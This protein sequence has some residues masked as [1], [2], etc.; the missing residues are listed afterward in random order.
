MTTR[1]ELIQS[2]RTAFAKG[3]EW[4]W[5]MA[6]DDYDIHHVVINALPEAAEHYPVP[7]VPREVYIDGRKYRVT[8]N[9]GFEY[10][11][12]N[13]GYWSP[14]SLTAERVAGLADLL[15]NPLT[16]APDTKGQ[17]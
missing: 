7:K 4:G 11:N 14:S 15:K 6:Q 8:E 1:N 3:A 2:Q 9:G 10:Y 12:A 16:D 5:Q 17:L 13:R